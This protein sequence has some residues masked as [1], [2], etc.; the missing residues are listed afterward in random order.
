MSLFYEDINAG[1]TWVTPR[2]T[3]TEADIV[4]FAGL[5][6]DFNPLHT[7]QVHAENTMFGR[8]IAHGMLVFSIVMGLRQ[9]GGQFDGTILAFLGINT[10]RFLKP[11]FI[12]D[13]IHAHTTIKDKR[14]SSNQDRGIMIQKIEV[15]NQK[16]E[17]AQEGEIA[18]MIQCKERS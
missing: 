8:R 16:E 17:I 11:V 1:D 10:W 15:L 5:S 4:N 3:I 13:T 9:R 12:G 18:I 2:R 6:G 14:K 7:D